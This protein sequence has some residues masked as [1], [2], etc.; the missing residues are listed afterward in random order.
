MLSRGVAALFMAAVMV[1][2]FGAT[3]SGEG[4]T[5][6][7]DEAGRQAWILEA[8]SGTGASIMVR[9]IQPPVVSI[10]TKVSLLEMADDDGEIRVSFLA[11]DPA[12]RQSVDG[13]LVADSHGVTLKEVASRKVVNWLRKRENA[14]RELTFVLSNNDRK[15]PYTFSNVGRAC[16]NPKQ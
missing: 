6:G 3:A 4:W 11:S 9:C 5:K 2:G 7:V 12:A 14:G 1:A 8:T 15:E 16:E 10:R 13:W